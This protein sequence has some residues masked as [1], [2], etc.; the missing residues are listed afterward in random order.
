MIAQLLCQLP[1]WHHKAQGS[2]FHSVLSC[3]YLGRAKNYEDQTLTFFIIVV[4][5]YN[6]E[7]HLCLWHTVQYNI[8]RLIRMIAFNLSRWLLAWCQR[9]TSAVEQSIIIFCFHFVEQGIKLHNKQLCSVCFTE[10]ASKSE[11]G[12][13]RTGSFKV[14]LTVLF[15]MKEMVAEIRKG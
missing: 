12:N 11:S 14:V 4:H 6:K 2:S 1:H 7:F 15:S 8:S 3:Y 9:M 13:L 10:C 5:N